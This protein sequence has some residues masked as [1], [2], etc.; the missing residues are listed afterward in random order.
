MRLAKAI[1]RIM[2]VN[3]TILLSPFDF[4]RIQISV[5]RFLGFS[6]VRIDSDGVSVT[7]TFVFVNED[8]DFHPVSI[9][10][11]ICCK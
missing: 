10:V 2:L 11:F 9:G 7:A 3:L 8:V 1:E 4:K 6:S 5:E